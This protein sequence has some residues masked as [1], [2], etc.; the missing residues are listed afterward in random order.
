V[1]VLR[2]KEK[3]KISYNTK[4]LSASHKRLKYF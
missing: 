3:N 1:Q 4:L 2:A